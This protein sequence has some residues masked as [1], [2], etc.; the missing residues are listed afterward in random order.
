MFSNIVFCAKYQAIF[1]R[2]FSANAILFSFSGAFSRGKGRLLSS[3]G[4]EPGRFSDGALLA[5]ENQSVVDGVIFS[6]G[7]FWLF[8]DSDGLADIGW[9]LFRSR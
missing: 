1:E 6:P 4:K 7:L 2:I 5:G 9:Y 8:S 3:F